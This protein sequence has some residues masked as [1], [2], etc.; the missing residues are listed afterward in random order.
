MEAFLNKPRPWWFHLLL[1][2][3]LVAAGYWWG[4]R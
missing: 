4:S 2:S 1:A 3:G